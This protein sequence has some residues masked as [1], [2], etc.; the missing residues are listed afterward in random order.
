MKEWWLSVALALALF[1]GLRPAVA[2]SETTPAVRDT[3][4]EVLGVFEAKCAGCHGPK[5]AKPKG[6]FGYIL[7][8]QRVAKNPEIVIPQRPTESEMWV[9]VQRG[10]M[11]PE[12]SPTGPLSAEQ[13]ETIRAW[14]AAGAPEAS[15]GASASPREVQSKEPAPEPSEK[16]SIGRLVRWVGKFHLLMLHFPIVLVLAAGVGEVWAVWQRKASPSETDRFIL[17]LGAV[18]AILTAGLGWLYAAAGHG[19][20]TPQLLMTHRWLGTTAAVVLIITALFAERDSRRGKRSRWV[21]FLLLA[22]V[23]ITAITAHFGGLM[24]HGVDF[25]TY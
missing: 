5:V 23:L 18:A 3:G 12:D 19:A 9:L 17:W 20:K 6:R 14:I 2:W 11:P 13:K 7:D 16:S 8:L 22:G 25:F 4:A 24:A 15:P 1:A 10:E 21:R